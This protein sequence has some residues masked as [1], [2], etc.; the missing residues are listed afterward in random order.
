MY[1]SREDA[2]QGDQ[3]FAYVVK[4]VVDTLCA[5]PTDPGFISGSEIDLA[6]KVLATC[7]P[8]PLALQLGLACSEEVDPEG[9]TV[10]EVVPYVIQSALADAFI[11]EV[12]NRGY[13]S[14]NDNKGYALA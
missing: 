9:E 11:R 2:R 8:A 6:A 13:V 5:K 1:R 12:K 14:R 3:Y 7:L 10:A 4:T